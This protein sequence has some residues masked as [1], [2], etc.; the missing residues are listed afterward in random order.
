M[1]KPPVVH[2]HNEILLRSRKEQTTNMY[3]KTDESQM[4]LSGEKSQ[5]LLNDFIYMISSK[6][7]LLRQKLYQRLIGA[8]GGR[9]IDY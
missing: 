1:A 4:F 8:K 6:G 2:P 3:T 5:T 7:K 9:S